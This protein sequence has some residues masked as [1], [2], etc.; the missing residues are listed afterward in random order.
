MKWT[1]EKCSSINP[2]FSYRCHNCRHDLDGL[3]GAVQHHE[4]IRGTGRST[5]IA[6]RLIA[7]AIENPMK[8]YSV[9]DKDHQFYGTKHPRADRHLL[10]LMWDIIRAAQ[11]DIE[12]DPARLR[13][14]SLHMGYKVTKEQRP[15]KIKP[16][17]D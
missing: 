14:R 2:Q 7:D 15:E 6:L 17:V 1:C 8:W 4:E 16:K 9:K 12:I 5:V 10:D 3:T 11:Y 13:I